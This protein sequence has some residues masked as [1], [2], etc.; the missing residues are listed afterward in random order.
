MSPSHMAGWRVSGREG[1][2][3]TERRE[4]RGVA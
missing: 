1:S 4:A 2:K 3:V